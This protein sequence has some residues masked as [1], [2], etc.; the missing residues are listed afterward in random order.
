M[1]QASNLQPDRGHFTPKIYQI[2]DTLKY[3]IH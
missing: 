3:S 1:K 2:G